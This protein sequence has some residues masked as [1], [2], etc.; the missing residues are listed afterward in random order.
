MSGRKD[1]SG[2]KSGRIYGIQRSR[3]RVDM[4]TRGSLGRMQREETNASSY[5]AMGKQFQISDLRPDSSQ[6]TEWVRY[7]KSL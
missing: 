5:H 7:I 3:R 6:Q 1:L 2:W 4:H